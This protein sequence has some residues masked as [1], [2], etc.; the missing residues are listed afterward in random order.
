MP[1]RGDG[2]GNRLDVPA[3]GRAAGRRHARGGRLQDRPGFGR[4]TVIGISGCANESYRRLALAHGFDPYLA[5]RLE[6]DYLQELLSEVA[7]EAD[8]AMLAGTRRHSKKFPQRDLR[9]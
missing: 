1:P 5:K 3:A 7:C 2:P 4:A 8:A 9:R 6:P